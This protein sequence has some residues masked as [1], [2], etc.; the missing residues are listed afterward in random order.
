MQKAVT[1][2][3]MF[4][5]LTTIVAAQTAKLQII[6]NA[7]DPA[8]AVVDVWV[9][10]KNTLDDFAF[11]SAT[12]FLDLP[13]G[14]DIIV[15]IAGPS[16]TMASE[17]LATFTLNLPANS[18]SIAIANGVLSST[19]FATQTDPNAAPITFN[20]FPVG[21]ARTVAGTAGNV[22]VLVW[23]G[24][25]D[26]PAVD[27][28]AGTSRVIES[29]SY[30]EAAEYLS[31]PP[32]EYELGIAPADGA[33]IAAFDADLRNAAGAAITVLASG[34]LNPAA[35]K[36][37]AAFGLFVAS[38]AGGPLTPL[39]AAKADEAMVQVIHNA[40]D[41]AATEVDVYV[42]GVKLLDNFAF[43]TASPFVPVPANTDLVIQVAGPTS[44]SASEAL[45]SFPVN[46][47]VGRYVIVANGVLNPSAFA[48]NTDP[49]A[50]PIAFSLYPISGVREA[51][52]SSGNVD[53]I[54]F[55]G[56]T[57]APAVDVYAGST[58]I[59]SG[60]SYG[61]NT[62]YIEVPTGSYVL[63]IAPQGGEAFAF[64][65]ADLTKLSGQA[66]TVVASGF[67]N[68][69]TNNN[70]PAFGLWAALTSGGALEQLPPTTASVVEPEVLG[71]SVTPNPASDALTLK[72][73]DAASSSWTISDMTG[74]TLL[75]GTFGVDASPNTIQVDV[76]AVPTGVYFVTVRSRGM[77]STVPTSIIR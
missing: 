32:A 19:G 47:P 6:H 72:V 42:N 48:P 55:H 57:D 5:A 73:D 3:M 65:N 22:D 13:A 60:A 52:A 21:N 39:P 36:D 23:H 40:A 38:A 53:L 30:G 54:V 70:G 31:V 66:V 49:N 27:I 56:A 63:G 7:A 14:V 17:A 16:S 64:F 58:K 20:V 18:T 76:N 35:N 74:L 75:S 12:P 1:V 11:R 9:N 33:M 15:G 67:L 61:Q 69:A 10:G 26:A 25:T 43:R 44:T 29:L 71:L 62:P 24:A 41:P 46:V 2:V 34:F 4:V 37:G 51:A 77:V 8:A 59:I 68:P 28:Y 50:S 45:A